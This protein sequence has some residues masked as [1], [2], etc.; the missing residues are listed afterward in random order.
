VGLAGC[1]ALHEKFTAASTQ[2]SELGRVLGSFPAWLGIELNSTWGRGWLC[3]VLHV[4][5]AILNRSWFT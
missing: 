2:H 3:L 5:G 4:T 1:W